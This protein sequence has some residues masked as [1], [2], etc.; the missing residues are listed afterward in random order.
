MFFEV[1]TPR[2]LLTPFNQASISTDYI[3]VIVCNGLP[4]IQASDLIKD[5]IF[6]KTKLGSGGS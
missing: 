6:F 1:K 5:F 3:H 2:D 4:L